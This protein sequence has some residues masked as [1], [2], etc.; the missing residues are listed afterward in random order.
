MSANAWIEN[1]AVRDLTYEDPYTVFHPEVAAFYN[2]EVPDGTKPGAT[3]VDGVWTNPTPV[4]AVDPA[5]ATTHVTYPTVGIV[6]FKLLF[7]S[8]ERQAIT[9]A[10]ATDEN[11][12]DFFSIIEDPRCDEVNLNL[13]SVQEMLQYLV[14]KNYIAAER[15]PQI[16]TGHPL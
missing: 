11:I 10:K 2:T 15:I 5:T 1:G 9:A 14:V 13:T 16:L 4:V 7:T 8:A 6:T 3:L 12:A